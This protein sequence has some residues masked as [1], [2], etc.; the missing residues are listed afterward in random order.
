LGFISSFLFLLLKRFLIPPML[1][2]S[3]TLIY[4]AHPLF[5]SSIAYIPNR[6]ELQLLF[7]S[8]VSFLFFIEFLQKRKN[9][10]LLLHWAAFTIALFCKETAA[11]LP[12]LFVVYFF[13]FSSEKRFEKKYFFIIMLYAVSGMFWF[14]LRSKAIGDYSTPD[15][16]FGLMPL[17]SNVKVIPEALA[18]FFLP[19]DFS[20]IPGFSILKISTGLGII[21][22]IIIIS[23]KNRVRLKK[24]IIF[25]FSWFLLLMLPPMLFKHPYIDYLDHRFFLPMIGILLY[26]LL[27]V[28]EKWFKNG[29]IKRLWILI[30]IFIILCSFTFI[31]ARSYSDPMTF[32]NSAVLQNSNS[33]MAYNNRGYIKYTMDDIK[34]AIGDYSKAIAICPTYDE[35]YNNR[36]YAKL[37]IGDKSGAIEDFNSAISI[38]NKNAEAYNNRGAAKM[39]IGNFQD[40]IEDY[41]KAIA[42]RPNY[43]EAYNNKGI[44]MN[45]TGRYSE[46]MI[47]LNKAIE[48]DPNHLNAYGNRSITKYHLKDFAG[49][50][51]DCE[52]IL[53]QNPDD[54]RA[55]NLKAK[56]QQELQKVSH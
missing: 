53:K 55:L 26:I 48:I 41:N 21:I 56:A 35:A 42:L 14:W 36:G 20:P 30:A 13:A 39:G 10:F 6:C 2:L 8:L 7:F 3:G 32:Y 9:I 49:A 25:C 33:A 45:S 47:Y 44:I 11:I 16:T 24:E 51:E 34:G 52:R 54:K 43:A 27:I 22:I 15:G 4:C 12:I 29:D 38:N 17:L 18:K 28:P 23:F 5:V 1:A 40:A 46:A 37:L 19:F 31:K 50:I